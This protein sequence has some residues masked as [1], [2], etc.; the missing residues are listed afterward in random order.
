MEKEQLKKDKKYIVKTKK[1]KEIVIFNKEHN[2]MFYFNHEKDT[3]VQVRTNQ[4]ELSNI[5]TS[6]KGTVYNLKNIYEV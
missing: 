1:G 2:G 5:F 3:V 4:P 6:G